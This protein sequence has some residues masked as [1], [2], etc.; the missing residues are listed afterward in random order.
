MTLAAEVVDLLRLRGATVAAAESLTGGLVCA[1]LVSVPGASDV[2]RGGVVAYAADVKTGLLG[3]D[4]LLVAARGT[5]DAEVAEAMAVR[6][7]AACDTT[8]GLATTGVA[9]PDDSEGKPPGTVHVAC[10]GPSGVVSQLVHLTGNRDQVRHGA[11]AAV[12]SLLV[13][14]LGEEPH[15]VQR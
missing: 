5:V 13:G 15:D 4:R 14:R 9:G 11:V 6:V 1:T 3:V 8:Y 2:V 10:A 7:R 12:L